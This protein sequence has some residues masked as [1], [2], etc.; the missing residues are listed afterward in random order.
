MGAVAF[1]VIIVVAVPII[2]ADDL[3]VRHSDGSTCGITEPGHV[4]IESG[5][6]DTDDLSLATETTVPDPGI[7][8]FTGLDDPCCRVIEQ[9]QVN[10]LFDPENFLG[11][12]QVGYVCLADL[13]PGP[14]LAH[15]QNR[16]LLLVHLGEKHR[17]VLLAIHPDMNNDLPA[18][19]Y[20]DLSLFIFELPVDPVRRLIANHAPYVRQ[21]LD[22][23]SRAVVHGDDEGEVRQVIA[24]AAAE[25]DKRVLLLFADRAG[26]LD[27]PFL[28]LTALRSLKLP[29]N[30]RLTFL[31]ADLVAVDLH[32]RPGKGRCR[33]TE[34]QDSN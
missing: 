19:L 33:Y 12:G 29:G 31:R 11:L 25:V 15:I 4:V 30:G 20:N 34:D 21:G 1:I 9:S 5:V 2:V 7:I 17:Q 18:F 22:L 26:E 28:I 13:D 16:T 3:S 27:D 6:T 32:L 8:C 24:D 10:G 23:L 14:V